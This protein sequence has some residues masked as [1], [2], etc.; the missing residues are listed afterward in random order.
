MK[1]AKE[2]FKIANVLEQDIKE[3]LNAH[4]ERIQNLAKEMFKGKKHAL[5]SVADGFDIILPEGVAYNENAP[6]LGQGHDTIVSIHSTEG[7]CEVED[8]TGHNVGIIV[9]RDILTMKETIGIIEQLE[10][11]QTAVD[12]KIG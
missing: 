8:E 2:L 1:K 10:K 12:I 5:A 9:T 7:E 3:T 11:I 6:D 4:L